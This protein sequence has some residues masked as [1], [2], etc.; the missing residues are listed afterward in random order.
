[1]ILENAGAAPELACNIEPFALEAAVT[2]KALAPSPYNTPLSVNA[3][4]PVP[5]SVTAKSFVN[6]TVPV[7][8][9]LSSTTTVPPAESRVKLP[10]LVSISPAAVTATLTLSSVAPVP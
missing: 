9:K 2:S 4:T 3:E 1:M 7:T 5:P 6:V 8:F 10:E